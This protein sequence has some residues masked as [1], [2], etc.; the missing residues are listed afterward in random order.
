[1]PKSP[2]KTKFVSNNDM[3]TL[4]CQTSLRTECVRELRFHN[5]RKWRFDYAL[6]EYRIA[7]EVEGGVWTGGRHT[8]P[9]GFLNDIE[10]YN[11]AAMMGWRVVRTTP[12]DLLKQA[13]IEML[14]K[15]IEI[16]KNDGKNTLK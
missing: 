4:L 3:F 16:A 15:F 9:K 1:M 13:T 10:K 7:L 2:K 11:T 6:P 14:R 5:V 12:D 8:S